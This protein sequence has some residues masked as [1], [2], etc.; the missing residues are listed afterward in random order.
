[1]KGVDLGSQPTPFENSGRATQLTT[2]TQRVL[3]A[4]KLATRK[5]ESFPQLA[6]FLAGYFLPAA[7]WRVEVKSITAAEPISSKFF[8]KSL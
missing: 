5:G 3:C 1:M 2:K 8:R 7:A 4:S 6:A